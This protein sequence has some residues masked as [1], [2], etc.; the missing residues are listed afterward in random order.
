MAQSQFKWVYAAQMYWASNGLH[1]HHPVVCR[2]KE[3]DATDDLDV[4]MLQEWAH[5][6]VGLVV[7]LRQVA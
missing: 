6:V 4:L 2:A 7:R 3:S 1:V 5:P